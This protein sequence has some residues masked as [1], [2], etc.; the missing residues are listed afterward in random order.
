[1]VAVDASEPRRA[2]GGGV[3]AGGDDEVRLAL[4]VPKA[5]VAFR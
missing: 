2:G 5:L 3:R 4:Y 1:M